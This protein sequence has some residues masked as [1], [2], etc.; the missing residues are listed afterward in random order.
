MRRLA[1]VATGVSLLASPLLAQTPLGTS[2]TYQGRLTE[3]NQPANGT[4]DFQFTIYGAASGSAQV[5]TVAANDIET[6]DD[7]TVTNSVFTVELDFCADAFDGDARWLEIAVRHNS[8]EFYTT[9]SPREQIASSPYAVRTLSASV[10][11]NALNL[12][13]IPASEYVT[14]SSVNSAFIRNATAPQS[15]NFN[16][17]GSGILGI[18]GIPGIGLG[19]ASWI[20]GA[21]DLRKIDQGRMDPSGRGPTKAGHICGIIGTILS[22][23]GLLC[24]SGVIGF[25]VYMAIQDASRGNQFPRRGF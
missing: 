12:G 11:D 15:A 13:G 17:T 6:R 10:A 5:C 1:L 4:Y 8:S 19:I 2:F 9:L 14:T 20:M 16:L 25:Q 23:L 22:I 3:N 21:A 18:L 7:V 24:I